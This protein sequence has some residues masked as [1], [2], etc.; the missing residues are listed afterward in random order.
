MIF[1]NNKESRNNTVLP[2]CIELLQ[3]L[4]QKG[5]QLLASPLYLSNW[6]CCPPMSCSF[7]SQQHHHSWSAQDLLASP[8]A[9]TDWLPIF[10]KAVAQKYLP[11]KNLIDASASH[12]CPAQVL[13]TR[14]NGLGAPS[15]AKPVGRSKCWFFA[16]FQFSSSD[17]LPY[18]HANLCSQ[19]LDASKGIP[20]LTE[21]L[22]K[23]NHCKIE[24]LAKEPLFLTSLNKI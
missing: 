21:K 17:P 8:S 12:P 9:G 23:I 14:S 1:P 19:P 6:T 16:S 5:M 2:L 10:L 18:G 4:W 20:Y 22:T 24:F 13:G 3:H 11:V 15:P 7:C